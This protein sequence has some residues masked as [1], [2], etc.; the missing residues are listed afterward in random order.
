M[1]QRVLRQ[2]RRIAVAILLSQL[3]ALSLWP[4]IAMAGLIALG[5]LALSVFVIMFA[6]DLRRGIECA[7]IGFFV[8]AQFPIA[9]MGPLF[10][11][12]GLLGCAVLYSPIMDLLPRRVHITSKQSFFLPF[13]IRDT[14]AR[15]I[16]G[17]GAAENHW[18][19]DLLDFQTDDDDP[20]TLYLR[21][22][23]S[24]GMFDE[25]TITF[26]D[27][28]E[29][30]DAR[31]AIEVD[32]QVAGE[33]IDVSYTFAEKSYKRTDVTSKMELRGMPLRRAFALW[34]DDTL[35]D[36]L[37]GVATQTHSHRNWQIVRAQA[38]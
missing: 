8:A 33:D 16:P 6:P 17:Q 5:A 36:E 34:F 7:A 20:D 32:H 1:F 21:Y 31:F 37:D 19:A 30:N 3:A 26:L 28:W 35:G 2:R 18:D 12:G 14:W 25:R 10:V 9:Y 38:V 15:V 24:D 11:I 13:D 27:F 23:K 22:R 4:G 29:G